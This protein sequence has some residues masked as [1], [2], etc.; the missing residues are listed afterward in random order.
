[1]PLKAVTATSDAGTFPGESLVSR[2]GIEG[3]LA[4]AHAASLRDRLAS[5]GNAAL[6]V[7]LAPGRTAERL[8]ARSGAA[9]HESQP[10]NRLRK[11]AGIE[12]V[13]T[14]LLRELVPPA[15]LT[16]PEGL[17]RLIG[18]PCRSRS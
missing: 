2:H 8:V 10:L 4:H 5:D 3:S 12:G 6:V 1:M 15:T 14:A 16:D 13:K 11:G 17:S 9:G 7:D 18:K